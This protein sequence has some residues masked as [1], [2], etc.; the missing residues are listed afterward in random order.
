M[1]G[2][3]ELHESD[4]QSVA[5]MVHRLSGIWLK[6]GKKALV[7]SRLM[8][9]VQVLGFHD[10]RAYL[11]YVSSEAG[12]QEREHMIDLLT[13]NK[14]EFF[15]EGEQFRFLSEHVL[16]SL[17][18]G[19]AI[20]LW[21][22]ACSSGEEPFSL[23]ILLREQLSD[24]ARRDVR[25]LATDIS[26]R[27]LTKAKEARYRSQALTG[28]PPIWRGRY[29]VPCHDDGTLYRLGE[30][31]RSMVTFARLNL[32]GN[33]PMKGPFHVIFC[34]NVMIYFDRNTQQALIDRFWH[35][36]APGGYLMVGHAEGLSG[37]THKFHY[38]QPAVYKK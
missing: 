25:I 21:S 36:L 3:A 12:D 1:L 7:R 6:D 18:K 34:R 5:E 35:L 17:P 37:I 30:E 16:S 28:V 24:I 29:F 27:M 38:V 31:I 2:M 22:A 19:T 8:K 13:T 32:I 15:R 23:A 33:W 4:F 10:F 26:L 9:R 14:T 20:R 11:K